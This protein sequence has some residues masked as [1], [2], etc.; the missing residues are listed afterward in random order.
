MMLSVFDVL[1]LAGARILPF[2]VFCKNGVYLTHQ[3]RAEYG[4]F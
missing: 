4:V 2:E 3:F 1:T